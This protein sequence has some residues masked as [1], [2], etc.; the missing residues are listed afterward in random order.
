MIC[1]EGDADG[2]EDDVTDG[3]V[4]QR[5]VDGAAHVLT[6]HDDEDDH[7]VPDQSD[8]CKKN[9]PVRNALI[10]NQFQS[11]VVCCVCEERRR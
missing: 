2:D 5:Q 11:G 10:P 7:Q 8:P 3:E 1:D 6:R 9:N 4:E